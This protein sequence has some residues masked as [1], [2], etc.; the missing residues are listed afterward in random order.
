MEK[1]GHGGSQ[2]WALS[3]TPL[4]ELPMY[5]NVLVLLCLFLFRHHVLFGAVSSA[6]WF[7]CFILKE[8]LS[9]VEGGDTSMSQELSENLA[10]SLK[11]CE[12]GCGE[13]GYISSLQLRVGA[14]SSKGSPM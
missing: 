3:A 8:H 12:R 9:F 10:S 4:A 2:L 5:C 7:G 6:L 14:G 11:G 13:R 1:G